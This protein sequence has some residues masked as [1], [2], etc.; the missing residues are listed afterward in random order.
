MRNECD[1]RLKST[2]AAD[3]LNMVV[4]KVRC[5]VLMPGPLSC[6]AQ[7]VTHPCANL[8]FCSGGRAVSNASCAEKYG[9]LVLS[10]KSLSAG[11]IG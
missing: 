3:D 9:T 6:S 10:S 4:S 5:A 2:R 8:G 7:N 11:E 1:E